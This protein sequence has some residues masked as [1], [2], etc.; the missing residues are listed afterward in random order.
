MVQQDMNTEA[1]DRVRQEFCRRLSA[2]GWVLS[3]LLALAIAGC[4]TSASKVMH[5]KTEMMIGATIR[6]MLTDLERG[7]YGNA[8]RVFTVRTRVG[9]TIAAV[10]DGHESYSTCSDVFIMAH[11][12][13]QVGL[14]NAGARL[15]REAEEAGLEKAIDLPNGEVRRLYHGIAARMAAPERV[16]VMSD[17]AWY[18]GKAIARDE[19]GHWR[20]EAMRTDTSVN[21][22]RSGVEE[23]C[24]RPASRKYLGARLCSLIGPVANGDIFVGAQHAEVDKLLSRVFTLPSRTLNRLRAHYG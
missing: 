8:C 24:A 10:L 1:C 13:D 15:K 5:S 3:V 19:N 21:E 22:L 23:E 17:T 4:G 7:S 11:V 14:A 18:Q 9:M 12:L 2:A 20:L 16:M 6:Q